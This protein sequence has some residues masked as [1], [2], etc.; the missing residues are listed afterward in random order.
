MN[1]LAGAARWRWLLLA[2]APLCWVLT[3][4]LLAHPPPPPPASPQRLPAASWPALVRDVPPALLDMAANAPPQRPLVARWEDP[5]AGAGLAA[6]QRALFDGRM[7]PAH[8]KPGGGLTDAAVWC[9]VPVQRGPGAQDRWLVV[10]GAAFLD[11]VQVWIEHGDG[12]LE[13]QQLGDR[14]MGAER[15]VHAREHAVAFELAPQEQAV[16]WVRARTSGVLNLTL[17]LV[18]PE[19]FFASEARINALLGLVLGGLVLAVL[20][21]L[22]LGAWL[23]DWLTVAFAAFLATVVMRYA[24]LTGMLAQLL[25]QAPWWLNDAVAGVGTLGHLYA[26]LWMW[27]LALDMRRDF[28]RMHRLYGAI[29]ALTL[30]LLALP[31]TAYFRPLLVAAFSAAPVIGLLNLG[32]AWVLWR[33]HRDRLRLVYLAAFG[34]YAAGALMAVAAGVGRPPLGEGAAYGLPAALMVHM[35]CIA[36]A[37]GLRLHRLRM[38]QQLGERRVEEHQRFVAMLAHE[39]RNPLAAIDRSANLLQV[40]GSPPPGQLQGRTASIRRQVQRLTLLVDSFL[41][42]NTD[43]ALP[44]VHPRRSSQSVAGFLHGLVQAL[45]AESAARVDVQL[46][47]GDFH[48][49]FDARLMQLALN[50]LL[51]NALRYSPAEAQVT[52]SAWQPEGGGWTVTV[53]DRGP[54]LGE[55]QL[56]QLGTPYHRM[57]GEPAGSQGTG[58]GYYFCRELVAAHGGQLAAGRVQP[59]GLCVRLTL[60]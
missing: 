7:R 39:F 2:A 28:P 58:L 3:V 36:F 12:R 22:V 54:G 46:P 5:G 37:L 15:L 35:L 10:V 47:Q 52:L 55:A 51:D 11:D 21:H 4:L 23:R 59:H 43:S 20:F 41:S 38:H 26:G 13:R 27:S 53:A 25:P 19:R 48:A 57:Q 9:A 18:R 24:G 14:W 29:A 30:P 1:A 50:N 31:V 17:Q 33:R 42:V 8:L 60:P 44:P 32:M 6:A 49:Q 56:R 16:V 45:D 40:L 34:A